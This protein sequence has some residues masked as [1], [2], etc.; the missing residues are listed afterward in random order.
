[1][2]RR[3]LVTLIIAGLLVFVAVVAF[4]PFFAEEMRS[5][6]T[7]SALFYLK[8]LHTGFRMYY[9]EMGVLPSDPRGSSYALYLLKDAVAG[10]GGASLFADPSAEQKGVAMPRFDDDRRM[11]VGSQY[12]YLNDP[13][14]PVDDMILLA[15]VPGLNPKRRYYLT[16]NNKVGSIDAETDPLANRPL[17]GLRLVDGKLVP[18]REGGRQRTGSGPQ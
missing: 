3:A 6:W 17:L 15:E 18:V 1:M 5:D 9:Q 10:V 8:R 11:L 12:D 7:P 16:L 2:R 14:P 13:R 4:L